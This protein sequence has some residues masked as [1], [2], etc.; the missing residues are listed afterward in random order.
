M[1][2]EK[3]DKTLLAHHMVAAPVAGGAGYPPAAPP[4]PIRRSRQLRSRQPGLV[5]KAFWFEF[6]Q[7]RKKRVFP[8]FEQW[9]HH[10]RRD[11]P[12][13][14]ADRSSFDERARIAERER[15]P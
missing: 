12:A 1:R 7:S 9:G 11:Q 3:T 13:P 4:D 6:D 14:S 15:L 10:R 8:A 5:R 2:K